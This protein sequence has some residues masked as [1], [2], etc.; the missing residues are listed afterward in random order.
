MKITYDPVDQKIANLKGTS[1]NINDYLLAKHDL[2]DIQRIKT[3]KG[4]L[5]TSAPNLSAIKHTLDSITNSELLFLYESKL[6]YTLPKWFI[7]FE[8]TDLIYYGAGIKLNAPSYRKTLLNTQEDIP[9]DYFNFIIELGKRNR[10]SELS[11]YFI[12]YLGQLASH[13]NFSDTL[14][15]MKVRDR[16]RILYPKNINYFDEN[17]DQPL[18]DYAYTNLISMEIVG[19]Y[20]QD[21]NFVKESIQKISNKSIATYLTNLR[22]EKTQKK[23]VA[24]SAAPNFHLIDEKDSILSL[25]LFKGSTVLISFWATWCKPCIKEFPYENKLLEEFA[26]KEFKIVSICLGSNEIVWRDK[27]DKHELKTINLFANEN[28]RIKIEKDYGIHGIPVYTLIDKSGNIIE[29][30]TLKPSDPRLKDLIS[31]NIEFR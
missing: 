5:N 28:W 24:G 26:D 30:K 10:D 20:L 9:A 17:Y 27:I 21:S 23:L 13:Y 14:Q 25:Q 15:E 1:K 8:E 4:T 6:K 11:T 3:I 18:R 31:K 29:H 22:S 2:F 7:A 19:G 16:L 12:Q